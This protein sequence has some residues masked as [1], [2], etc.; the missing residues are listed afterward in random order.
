MEQEKQLTGQTG[1]DILLYNAVSAKAALSLH[2]HA[3]NVKCFRHS[4]ALTDYCTMQ[5]VKI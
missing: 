2:S 4:D 5:K 1:Y 3:L